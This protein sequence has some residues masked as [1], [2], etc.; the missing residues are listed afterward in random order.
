MGAALDEA[1]RLLY[2]KAIKKFTLQEVTKSRTISYKNLIESL[3]KYPG[4]GVGFKVWSKWWP[5][6]TFYHVRDVRV[7][8][9]LSFILKSNSQED[10]GVFQA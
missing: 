5:E 10:M 7:F 8:V 6:G 4:Y 9:I 2:E 1:R 3:T